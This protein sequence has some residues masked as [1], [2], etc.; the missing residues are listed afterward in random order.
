[1]LDT[2]VLHHVIESALHTAL[3]ILRVDQVLSM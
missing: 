3:K 2:H 1:V